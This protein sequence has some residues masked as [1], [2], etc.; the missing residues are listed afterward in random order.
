MVILRTWIVKWLTNIH[1]SD[2]Y[3]DDY[4][5]K[6]I[7]FVNVYFV[8]NYLAEFNV[9]VSCMLYNLCN[10]QLQPQM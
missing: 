2:T 5:F 9:D 4:A 6:H 8:A 10:W 7:T 3:I 1:C